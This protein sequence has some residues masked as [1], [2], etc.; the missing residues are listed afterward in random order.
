M[1]LGYSIVTA[2]LAVVMMG[3]VHSDRFTLVDPTAKTEYGPFDYRNGAV[4]RV[5]DHEYRIKKLASADQIL[6]EQLRHIILPEIEFRDA[7]IRDVVDFLNR[8]SLEG[9][10]GDMDELRRSPAYNIRLLLPVAEAT[11]VP[12]VTFT[13]RHISEYD[14]LASVAAL[15]GGRFTIE[16]GQA[17][18]RYSRK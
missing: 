10:I 5:A 15:T 17:W 2:S 7:G 13:A 8:P 11:R 16:N 1:R 3:C 9:D 4:L 12:Q 18:L 6:E 14:L